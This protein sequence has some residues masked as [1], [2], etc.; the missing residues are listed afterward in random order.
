MNKPVHH[1]LPRRREIKSIHVSKAG[2]PVRA[3][4]V[5]ARAGELEKLKRRALVIDIHD[6]AELVINA[7]HFI[8]HTVITRIQ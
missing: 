4:V 1:D 7:V 8:I 3:L 2:K 6:T 5:N